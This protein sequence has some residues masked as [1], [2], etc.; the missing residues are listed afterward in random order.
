MPEH[1]NEFHSALYWRL[2]H[3][4]LCVYTKSSF[5]VYSCIVLFTSTVLILY[6]QFWLC[7]VNIYSFNITQQSTLIWMIHVGNQQFGGNLNPKSKS[8]IK[9]KKS[10]G[11]LYNTNSFSECHI[12]FPDFFKHKTKFSRFKIS[13]SFH[14]FYHIVLSVPSSC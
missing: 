4:S 12:G 10:S 8:L 7:W 11:Y 13:V 14:L 5:W 2:L 6:Y 9:S 3:C 1:I